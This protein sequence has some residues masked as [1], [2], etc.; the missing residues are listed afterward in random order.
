MSWLLRYRPDD[1]GTN[2]LTELYKDGVRVMHSVGMAN[3]YPGD[4]EAY[5]K[6]GIYKWWWK[7]RPSDVSERTLYYGNVEIAER[8]DV[9]R[10]GRVE[11]SRR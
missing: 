8:G 4:K 5:L 3:A 6:I 1:E 11:S 2:A 7:T 9:T 10:A